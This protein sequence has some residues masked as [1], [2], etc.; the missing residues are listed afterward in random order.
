MAERAPRIDPRNATKVAEQVK[1][2]LKTDYAPE[3]DQDDRLGGALIAVFARF[4]ELV[5]ERLNQ[6]PEKNFLAFLDLLGVSRLPPQPARVPL[7][8]ILAQGSVVDVVVPKGT[9]VGASPDP[10]E[11]RPVLFE[12]EQELVVA[13]VMLS[14]VAVRE[15]GEDKYA[16]AVLTPESLVKTIEPPCR[17]FAGDSCCEHA[18]YLGHRALFSSPG[19]NSLILEFNLEEGGNCQ[20]VWERHDGGQWRKIQPAEDKTSGLK[21]SGS[22][23]LVLESPLPETVV[24]KASSRWLRCRLD[25]PIRL[26]WDDIGK[27]FVRDLK[28][29]SIGKVK[30]TVSSVRTGLS[31]DAAL[32]NTQT[33]DLNQEFFLFSEKPKLG[34]SFYLAHREAFSQAGAA[35]TLKIMVTDPSNYIQ[36]E[37]IPK[38]RSVPALTWGYWNGKAWTMLPTNDATQSFTKIGPVTATFTVPSDLCANLVNGIESYW[39]RVRITNGDYGKEAGVNLKKDDKGLPI[40]NGE[41]FVYTLQPA[42]LVPP[43]IS[44]LSLDYTH[45]LSEQTPET[46]LCC[47]DFQYES[48]QTP[49][50]TPFSRMADNQTTFY[51]GFSLPDGVACFPKRPLSIYFSIAKKECRHT[52]RNETITPMRSPQLVW[53]YW[54][55]EKWIVTTVKDET[56]AFLRTGL[57]IW[58]PPAD[59][60]PRTDFGASGQYWVRARLTES[61]D[62][63]SPQLQRVLLNTTLATQTLTHTNEI[64]GSS[65]ENKGQR[66]RTTQTPILPGQQLEVEEM[67]M[68]TAAELKIIYREEGQDAVRA[69]GVT[70]GRK[71]V[72]VRW[73]EVPDFH[74]ACCRDRHYVVDRLGGEICFGDGINGLIPPRGVGNIRLVRYQTGGGQA[75]NKPA[76]TVT[77]LQTTLP[78]IDKVINYE[79]AIGGADA[80]TQ[81]DMRERAPKILRHHHRAVTVEDFEDLALLASPKVARA[82]CV[83]LLN[84]ENARLENLDENREAKEKNGAGQIGVIIVPR[85]DETKP[86]PDI[87][88]IH[89]VRDY[90]VKHA[91]ATATVSVAGPLYLSLSVNMDVV[92][93]TPEAANTVVALLYQKVNAF[94][95]PLTGGHY[96]TGW[97]FGEQPQESDVYRL[98]SEVDG[99]D[100]VSALSVTLGEIEIVEDGQDKINKI[101]ETHRFL[102]YSGRHKIT[103]RYEKF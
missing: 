54:N 31:A 102:I 37:L 39:I 95:H 46:I 11:Q 20:V 87:E 58:L 49:S 3:W 66:Y 93:Q 1:R 96:G 21:V 8:F 25:N 88:L 15:P 68:P 34:D 61:G 36:K 82:L 38:T 91:I 100:H 22:V 57:I 7:T 35:V 94:L 6:V 13:P 64:L 73:H 12:T 79:P 14:A 70:S 28:L 17:V 84:V 59:I 85:S 10:G 103:C 30:M 53:E 90:L 50:F 27:T 4:T 83:P 62:F 92:L 33:I 75:G 19:L 42:T 86:V 40:K 63:P 65:N 32:A 80:E 89:C 18:M 29:P 9:Q 97:P 26:K 52:A 77:Q 23:K 24:N 55:G 56:E 76:G 69:A 81:E 101:R 45:S 5:I 51:M 43:Q 74:G 47:N 16:I 2:L 60:R 71:S 44:G 98:I 78:Y 72:W 48:P 99:V 41:D 67:E